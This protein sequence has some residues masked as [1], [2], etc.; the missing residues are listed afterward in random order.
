MVPTEDLVHLQA[1]PI[2]AARATWAD[3][4]VGD[5]IHG[6]AR[7]QGRKILEHRAEGNK[8]HQV[9]VGVVA[10]AQAFDDSDDWKLNPSAGPC[11]LPTAVRKH[12]AAGLISQHDDA[13]LLGVVHVLIQRP[14]ASGK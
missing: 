1:A 8:V 11:C 2:H 10:V 14:C 4:S 12:D 5:G 13:P 9:L 7:I 3:S 6:L